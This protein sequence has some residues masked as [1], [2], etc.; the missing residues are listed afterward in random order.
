MRRSGGRYR[1][2]REVFIE[3]D[4][5]RRGGATA[6]LPLHAHD[7]MHLAPLCDLGVNRNRPAPFTIQL[8]ERLLILSC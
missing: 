8:E 1:R 4:E 7:G 5:P 2:R 3:G 6:S